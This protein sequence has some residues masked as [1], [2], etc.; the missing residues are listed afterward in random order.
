MPAYNAEEYIAAAMVS[1]LQQTYSNIELI[2]VN[3]GSADN[4]R[5]IAESFKHSRLRVI[6]HPGNYGV[7]ESHNTGLSVAEGEYV[8][9]LDS[10]DIALPDRIERQVEFMQRNPWVGVVGGA[11]TQFGEIPKD[12]N[13]RHIFPPTR[14]EHLYAQLLLNASF[15]NTT[16]MYRRVALDRIY[17][18][19]EKK[20]YVG[21]YRSA[22]DYNLY[23][24]LLSSGWK[25][26]SLQRPLTLQRKH[27][28]SAS[29]HPDNR[30]NSL[31]AQMTLLAQLGI[32][33]THEQKEL[34]SKIAFFKDYNFQQAHKDKF[35]AAAGTWIRLILKSNI[36]K[37]VFSQRALRDVFFLRWI[38]LAGIVQNNRYLFP[39]S[40]ISSPTAPSRLF[41]SYVLVKL[42]SRYA[43]AIS[44]PPY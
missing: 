42:R 29:N 34:H 9:I 37:K 4:T 10:D 28:D 13:T 31:D 40:I 5:A 7:S 26:A 27:A 21:N 6:N 32:F 14:H 1:V 16:L 41:P 35:L 3:D 18:V 23:A 44:V 30:K 19:V 20:Y 24:K 15:N 11:V 12:L 33:P 43:K 22:E 17:D 2:I 38:L 8:A 25:A 39:L 36:E